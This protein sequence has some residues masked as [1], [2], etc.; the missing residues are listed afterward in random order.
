MVQTGAWRPPTV[1]P[2]PA[3]IIGSLNAGVEAVS[4]CKRVFITQPRL[5][6]IL[7]KHARP[8]GA[9]V[10]GGSEITAVADAYATSRA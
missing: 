10:L 9:E 8:S 2:E 5:E 3:D 1:N 7:R 6:P 4:P